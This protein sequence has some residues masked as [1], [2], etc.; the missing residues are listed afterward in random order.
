MKLASEGVALEKVSN[1]LG[2][3]DV[4]EDPHLVF[5]TVQSALAVG[6]PAEQ[7]RCCARKVGSNCTSINMLGTSI[8][9][10]KSSLVIGN[11]CKFADSPCCERA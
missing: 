2:L 11:V 6:Y 9:Q 5:E 3:D 8:S 10:V 7:V 1:H 4:L